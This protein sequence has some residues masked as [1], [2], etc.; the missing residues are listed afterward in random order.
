MS[1][2]ALR[3]VSTEPEPNTVLD[4]PRRA[5]LTEGEV[6]RLIR[7]TRTTRDA[8]MILM[9]YRHGLRVSE[10]VGAEWRQL[11]RRKASESSDNP[12]P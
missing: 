2:S 5:Y 9:G 1:N 3:T 11:G 12:E 4:T 7:A 10:L 6:E 8:M